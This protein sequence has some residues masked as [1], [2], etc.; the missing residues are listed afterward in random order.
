MVNATNPWFL[1]GGA[2]YRDG[3]AG[4]FAYGNT[5]GNANNAYSFRQGKIT[6]KNE[7]ICKVYLYYFSKVK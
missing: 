2:D 5:N 3:N 4:V 1:R 7:M 6:S